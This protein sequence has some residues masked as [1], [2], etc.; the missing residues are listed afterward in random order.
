MLSLF[1]LYRVIKLIDEYCNIM[2]YAISSKAEWVDILCT[3][4]DVGYLE[5]IKAK[6]EEEYHNRIE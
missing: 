1:E 3:K 6:L 4:T 2:G 5:R